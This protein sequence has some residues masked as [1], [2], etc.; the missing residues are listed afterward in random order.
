MWDMLLKRCPG[1]EE[2]TLG[3]PPSGCHSDYKFDLSPM[4][5]G[6]WPKLQSLVLGRTSLGTAGADSYSF[7]KFIASHRNLKKFHVIR[8]GLSRM[9]VGSP[10]ASLESFAGHAPDVVDVATRH[11]SLKELIMTST[12]TS[13][14]L[15]QC[16][17]PC[18][19]RM[20]LLETLALW[21]SSPFTM[22]SEPNDPDYQDYAK[23][24]QKVFQCHPK[25]S[26]FT[27]MC[28]GK[29]FKMVSGPALLML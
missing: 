11:H 14:N 20:P 5:K 22:E 4:T 8:S 16:L 18:L 10:P 17:L 23:V 25:L 1:L 28:S 2:L 7:Q 21:I 26:N 15:V 13:L 3:S 12:D 9:G 6:R 19:Q 29:D 27:L 24:L